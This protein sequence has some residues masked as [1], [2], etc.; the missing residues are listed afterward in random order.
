MRRLLLAVLVAASLPAV[1][2]S[3][4][5]KTEQYLK[6]VAAAVSGYSAGG[7]VYVVICETG[8]EY[9][10][11]GAFGTA[12]EAQAAATAGKTNRTTCNVEGPY[13]NS[14]GVP[15]ADMA[16]L[17]YGGGCKK[18]PDSDCIGDST[19]AFITPI[20]GIQSVTIT[21]TLR[22][23]TRRSEEFDPRKVEAIFF[24]M[25]AVDRMLIPYYVRV[26]G[27]S[28]AV[29]RRQVLLERYGVRDLTG[30]GGPR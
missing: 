18:G 19:R 11:I 13:Y 30:A 16:G 10:V 15:G 20:G 3:Q 25:P 28:G 24:T 4:G 22:D 23:G 26:Y 12:A 21:Y 7:P 6:L 17:P 1:C 5:G 9:K 8:G 29:R 27:L 2:Q 14:V